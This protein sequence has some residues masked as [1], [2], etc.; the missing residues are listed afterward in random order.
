MVAI[1][2]T[3]GEDDCLF[4]KETVDF[5]YWHKICIYLE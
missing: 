1:I 4:Y 5:R 2:A 3:A